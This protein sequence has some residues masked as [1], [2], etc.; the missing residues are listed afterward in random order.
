MALFSADGTKMYNP[1]GSP[2]NKMNVLAEVAYWQHEDS[3]MQVAYIGVRNI[4]T[5]N[6][7]ELRDRVIEPFAWLEASAAAALQLTH[8]AQYGADMH[9]AQLRRLAALAGL[10]GLVATIGDRAA[11]E[12]RFNRLLGEVMGH[13][14]ARLLCSMHAVDNAAQLALLILSSKVLEIAR[15][16]IEE[17]AWAHGKDVS[18]MLGPAMATALERAIDNVGGYKQRGPQKATELLNFTMGSRVD[19]LNAILSRWSS[20]CRRWQKSWRCV[21]NLLTPTLPVFCCFELARGS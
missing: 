2:C 16:H 21:Y 7:E 13:K 3:S 14:L 17:L 5:E 18:V 4:F 11:N 12:T 10:H 1:D 8:Q 15:A 19:P 9:P 6:R 20:T